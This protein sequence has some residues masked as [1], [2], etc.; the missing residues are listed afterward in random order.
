MTIDSQA[1]VAEAEI[2]TTTG[3]PPAATALPYPQGI[4]RLIMRLPVV[5][6]RL[7]L[8]RLLGSARLMVLT[9]RGRKTGLPRHTAIEYRSHGSKLYIISGWGGRPDWFQNIRQ[10]PVVTVQIGDQARSM[11]AHPLTDTDEVLRALYLFRKP[12]PLIFDAVL[13]QVCGAEVSEYTLPDISD[14]VTAV[15]LAP[16]D[17][18]GPAPVRADLW[19]WWLAAL[20]LLVLIYRALRR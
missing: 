10:H 11:I 4:T 15:R 19:W 2:P 3:T 17:A 14:R 9:T 13:T 6:Y 5:L 7:G 12:T 20:P 16:T 18:V 1:P 8:G